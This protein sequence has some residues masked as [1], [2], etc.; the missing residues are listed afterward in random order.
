MISND[1]VY[2]SHHF[3]TEYLQVILFMF[4]VGFV[5]GAGL[6]SIFAD[7]IFKK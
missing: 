7:R 4:L 6:M 3:F 5:L 2:L 1:V